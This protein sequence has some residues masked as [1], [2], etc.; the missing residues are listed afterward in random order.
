MT[1][2]SWTITNTEWVN[3]G[4]GP[5]VV[6]LTEWKPLYVVVSDTKP[7]IDAE[8]Q[9]IIGQGP[10]GIMR[11]FWNSEIVWLKCADVFPATTIA[12]DTDIVIEPQT[13]ITTE[14]FKLDTGTKTA[15][16]TAGAA[17]LDK[18]SGKITSESL[19]TAAGATYTLTLTD[20]Q[21]AAA[22]LVFASVAL[23]SATTGMPTITTIK[24]AA[25]SVVIIVQNIH[26][27]AA[28]NGTIVIAFAVIKGA[29]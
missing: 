23:G 13:L 18:S 16:A 9:F 6:T 17:T 24:P 3:I 4:T 25:G 10:S 29:A 15:S 2:T 11:V 14:Q 19:T 8:A 5:L 1:A 12:V 27:S 21:I 7:A 26:A 22:D 20:S 28:L